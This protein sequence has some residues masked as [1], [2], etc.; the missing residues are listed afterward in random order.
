M[1]TRGEVEIE[2]RQLFRVTFDSVLNTTILYCTSLV[3]LLAYVH[4]AAPYPSR[5]CMCNV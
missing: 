3:S 2:R 5:S 1:D 4:A